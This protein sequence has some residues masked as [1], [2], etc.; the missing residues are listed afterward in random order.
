MVTK[1]N[2]INFKKEVLDSDAPVLVGCYVA[3]DSSERMM[4]LFEALSGKYD[5]KIKF[6]KLDAGEH[7]KLAQQ[8]NVDKMPTLLLFHDG[9]EFD[10]IVGV[11]PDNMLELQLNTLLKKLYSKM[12]KKVK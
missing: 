4:M 2:Y 12:V 3:G 11:M 1:L 5:D 9:K 10:R 6:V 7:G 8:Y